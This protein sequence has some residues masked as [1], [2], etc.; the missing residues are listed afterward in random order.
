MANDQEIQQE[1]I[2][3][4]EH[5][6]KDLIIW[7]LNESAI[8]EMT[9]TVRDNDP[10]KMEISKLYSMFLLRF[11]PEQNKFDSRADF[12]GTT[13]G[14]HETAEVVWTRKI[15]VDKNCEFEN[16]TPAELIASKF[17]FVILR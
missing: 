1:H 12:F 17:P 11:I 13:R 16:V 10:K 9:R 7:V 2:D 3:E 15:K 8:T 14:K 6:I 4:L 5:R